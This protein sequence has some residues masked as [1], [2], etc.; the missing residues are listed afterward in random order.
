MTAH[1]DMNPFKGRRVDVPVPTRVI[2][3]FTKPTRGAAEIRERVITQFE[4]LEWLLFVDGVLIESRMYHGDRAS[5]Y[6]AELADLVNDLKAD[7]WEE[8]QDL[9][10]RQ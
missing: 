6:G 3:R 4:A 1:A 5:Q 8:D 9:L 2:R 10:A 7:G